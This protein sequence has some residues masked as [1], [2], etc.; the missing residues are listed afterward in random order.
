VLKF[1]C[2]SAAPDIDVNDSVSLLVRIS[3]VFIEKYRKTQNFMHLVHMFC[4]KIS[5]LCSE[6]I[7]FL[8]KI[9]VCMI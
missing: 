1:G 7:K 2:F 5:L 9:W 3:G 4:H 8:K 6:K